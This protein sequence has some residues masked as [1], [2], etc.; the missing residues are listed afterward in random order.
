LDATIVEFPG[1]VNLQPGENRDK[2]STN[3]ANQHPVSNTRLQR[4]TEGLKIDV[5][6]C[7]ES[8]IGVAYYPLL[9]Y[10]PNQ[11]QFARYSLSPFACIHMPAFVGEKQAPN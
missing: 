6:K 4:H 11:L 8:R 7:A 5:N 2:E 1:A 10:L 3:N 9:L